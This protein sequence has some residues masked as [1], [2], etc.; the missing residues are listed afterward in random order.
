MAWRE[1][2]RT[3]GVDLA[4]LG[5]TWAA[6][7][8]RSELGNNKGKFGQ[9]CAQRVGWLSE[10]LDSCKDQS[11]GLV[12]CEAEKRILKSNESGLFVFWAVAFF[13]LGLLVGV[14]LTSLCFW[15]FWKRRE[16]ETVKGQA[17]APLE[18]VLPRLPKLK[19]PEV[20]SHDESSGDGEAVAAARLRARSLRG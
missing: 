19:D 8:F 5:I 4:R 1:G 6:E 14:V 12:A 3:V 17:V 9:Y 2:L 16:G 18:V 10:Q 13:L 7:A 11:L 20:D 15:Q